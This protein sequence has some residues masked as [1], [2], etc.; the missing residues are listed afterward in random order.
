MTIDLEIMAILQKA[1]L[2]NL[3]LES[4]GLAITQEMAE[5]YDS[6]VRDYASAPKGSMPQIIE[7]PE[8]GK[9]DALEA[10]TERAHGP[11]FGDKPLR[12]LMAERLAEVQRQLTEKQD[13][14]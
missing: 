4:T 6:L 12:Q 7:D 5:A 11:L 3:P 2:Q 1:A 14:S 8:W 10:A 13:E 9:W